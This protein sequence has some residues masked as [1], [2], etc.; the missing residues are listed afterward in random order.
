VQVALWF[1]I[2][3]ALVLALSAWVRARSLGRRL[4]RLTKQFWDLR[5]EH[6]ELRARVARLDPEASPDAAEPQ[7]DAPPA[8]TFIPLSSLKR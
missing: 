3:V 7:P 1:G 2:G 4:E 8:Q 5:Y 6:G